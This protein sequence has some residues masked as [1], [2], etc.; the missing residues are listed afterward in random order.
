MLPK[1]GRRALLGPHQLQHPAPPNLGS[2]VQLTLVVEYEHGR[3]VTWVREKCPISPHCLRQVG[4]LALPMRE[5]EL[6]LT[7]A[8]CSIG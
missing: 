1:V 6:T 2:T 7:Y 8:G 3:A 4:Q 5:G